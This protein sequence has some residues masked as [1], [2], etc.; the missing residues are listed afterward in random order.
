MQKA[1]LK[2]ELDQ[3]K[4]IVKQQQRDIKVMPPSLNY[5]VITE[6]WNLFTPTPCF[7]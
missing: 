6:R 5:K 1:L 4:S 2:N 3:H 7:F